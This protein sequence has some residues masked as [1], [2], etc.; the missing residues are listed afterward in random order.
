MALLS[1]YSTFC[2]FSLPMTILLAQRKSNLPILWELELEVRIHILTGKKLEQIRLKFHGYV[3]NEMEHFVSHVISSNEFCLE[4]SIID[5]FF[6]LTLLN[7]MRHL[8]FNMFGRIQLH[9]FIIMW[10]DTTESKSDRY[11]DIFLLAKR[12]I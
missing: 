7:V 5:V 1:V 8:Q 4:M 3:L 12:M 2:I 9:P 10:D 11:W 6:L